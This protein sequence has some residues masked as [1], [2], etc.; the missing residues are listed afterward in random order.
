MSLYKS[1]Q[2]GNWNTGS[3]WDS[4]S[5]PS[6]G[7][8]VNIYHTVTYDKDDKT[9]VLGNV[10]ILTGGVLQWT[11]S[12]NTSSIF[13]LGNLRQ[14]GGAL[15]GRAGTFIRMYGN[16]TPYQW[17][18][19]DVSGSNVDMRGS[20]PNSTAS[21]SSD[22]PTGSGYVDVTDVTDASRFGPFDY[23]NIFDYSNVAYNNRTD[24]VFQVNSV[25]GSRI[26]LRRMIGPTLPLVSDTSIGTNIFSSSNDVRCW[27]SGYKF[28]IDN[29]IFTVQSTDYNNYNVYT[30]ENASDLHVS[31]TI[32]YETG[33]EIEHTAGKIVYKLCNVLMANGTSGTS[34]IDVGSAGGWKAG[35]VLGI[36]GVSYASATIRTISSIAT[37]SGVGG[38]DRI[39]LTSNLSATHKKD[40]L[41]VKINRDCV[42]AGKS[43]D[44]RGDGYC[45]FFYTDTGTTA[46]RHKISIEN[47]QMKYIGEG[48][49]DAR[50][51]FYSRKSYT[52][53]LNC[54]V[55][56]GVLSTW[57]LMGTMNSSYNVQK[58]NVAYYSGKGSGISYTGGYS[59]YTGNIALRC[60]YYPL[61]ANNSG[62]GDQWEY[63]FIEGSE[64]YGFYWINNGESSYSTDVYSN[65]NAIKYRYF[66]M[67]FVPTP[68]YAYNY[69]SNG[70]II[71]RAL[72]KNSSHK[73]ICY[74]ETNN[75][76]GT[77][78]RKIITDESWKTA[79]TANNSHAIFGSNTFALLEQITLLTEYNYIP[80]QQVMFFYY[81]YAITDETIKL[82][83]KHS[84][85]F[86]PL[87]N[88]ADSIIG[89]FALCQGIVGKTI[90]IKT[91]VKK[92]STFNG[93]G[94]FILIRNEE[95]AEMAI[96]TIEDVDDI[97]QQLDLE[98]TFE[99]DGLYVVYIGGYGSAGN[100]WIDSPE[101]N[102]DG[103]QLITGIQEGMVKI[104]S[105]SSNK[106]CSIILN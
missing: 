93:T 58:N 53:I 78:L 24:E 89:F 36:G 61:A 25:S 55:Q 97:W 18:T 10:S 49:I 62:R 30:I 33:T 71:E 73:R 38:S 60:R 87:R 96:T 14:A 45:G 66:H 99:S 39:N 31:G 75:N 34:Y 105:D 84:W 17:Y 32:G 85:K 22:V 50:G 23:V 91:F 27:K 46:G 70:C 65:R 63:N 16:S 9:T 6:T 79:T 8:T 7:D 37:G 13:I 41:I 26:Y 88:D 35:D 98:Y 67:N 12:S 20:W 106:N 56:D 94:P 59:Y 101:I 102:G 82:S 54:S 4:G 69:L 95:F 51:G 100:F 42:F 44:S 103:F 3:T 5:V 68:F 43:T 19:D 2:D 40:G 47:F 1:I 48:R 74:N 104:S 72:I 92:D 52:K 80:D 64:S 76:G 83:K 15:V 28:V 57:G 90:R 21:L 29:E 77:I 81:G 11:G 86:F